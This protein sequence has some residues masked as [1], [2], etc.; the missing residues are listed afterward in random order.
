MSWYQDPGVL[1]FDPFASIKPSAE[2]LSFTTAPGTTAIT[3]PEAHSTTPVQAF[4]NGQAMLAKDGGRYE[5]TSPSADTATIEL[6]LTPS[7][8]IHGGAAIPEPITL[9]TNGKGVMKLGDWSKV[10]VLH[11]YSGGIKYQKSI[12]LTC[13]GSAA[14]QHP[15][16]RPGDRHRGSQHQWQKGGRACCPTMAV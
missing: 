1:L 10:G 5:A 3:I 13:G 12:T 4:Y 15:R 2:T 16:P 11:N 6:K 7:A 8:G 9:H 14:S